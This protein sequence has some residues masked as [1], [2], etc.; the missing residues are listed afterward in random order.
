MKKEVKII[1]EPD[2]HKS[3]NG[4]VFE[5]LIRLILE[6]Q[7]YQVTK[8]VLITGLEIDLLAK[9]RLKNEVLY[10]ECKAKEKPKS[11]EIKKFIFAV[12]YGIDG[13]KADYGYFIHTEELDSH[14][15]GLQEQLER[16]KP[17]VSFIGPNKIFE[18]LERSNIVETFSKTEIEG[19]LITKLTLAYSY[20]GIFYVAIINVGSIP[21]FFS[22]FDKSLKPIDDESTI[23]L[24]KDSLKDIQELEYL[25]VSPKKESK[26]KTSRTK[27]RETNEKDTITDIK[28][29]ENWYDYTPASI[30]HFIGRTNLKREIRVFIDNVRKAETN[31][32]VFLLDGKSGWGK[33]S[34][35]AELRGSSQ[36]LKYWKSRMHVVAVDTRSANTVNFVGLAF[37]KLVTSALE[38]GFIQKTI[39]SKDL[40]ITS[41]YNVLDDESVKELFK[42]LKKRKK[43]LVL[44]FDQFED[45]FRDEKLFDA[46][47]QFCIDV[48]DARENLVVGFSWKSEINVPFGN[49]ASN[50]FNQLRDY[51][52]CI[53]I[54]EFNQN[55]AKQVVRQLESSI[56][57]PIGNDLERRL[58]E[59]SQGY[60]WLIKKLCIHT[61]KQYEKGKSIEE[62][63]EQ[64]LNYKELF[65]NDLLEVGNEEKRL[66]DHIALRAYDGNPFDISELDNETQKLADKL[67]HM[68]LVI[69]TG[70][71]YNIYWD[72]FRDYIVTKEIPVLG[73]SYLIRQ[74]GNTCL[75]A[76]LIF[77]NDRKLPLNTLIDYYP[78]Q[79]SEKAISNI[80]LELR[81]LGLL[82]KQKGIDIFEVTDKV[83]EV[84]KE[85]FQKYITQ[86]F[87]NYTP[88]IELQKL[89]KAK[90]TTDDIKDVL[91]RIFKTEKF[92]ENTWHAYAKQL[93]IWFGLSN[94]S[95]KDRLEES[96]R[97]S[98]TYSINKVKHIPYYSPAALFDSYSNVLLGK[99]INNRKARDLNL[100]GL[101][102]ENGDLLSNIDDLQEHVYREA[103]SIDK[104]KKAYDF[105]KKKPQI[106][107]NDFISSNPK[108]LANYKTLT[109]KKQATSII[110]VWVKYCIAF[111]SGENINV[112]ARRRNNG[113]YYYAFGPNNV[114]NTIKEFAQGNL[115][116]EPNNKRKLRDIEHL[117]FLDFN[118]GE[119]KT[120]TNGKLLV[121][122]LKPNSIL[123]EFARKDKYIELFLK[124]CPDKN[125]SANIKEII[126]SENEFFSHLASYNSK[127]A[128]CSIFFAWAKFL[129]KVENGSL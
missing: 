58:V 22:I 79:I 19:N 75:D 40:R 42:E 49:K 24:L 117:G 128:K 78:K 7:E 10:A 14:A 100:I 43:T 4:T 33:S 17:N 105:I 89:S 91:K 25:T 15:S 41:P 32:R 5:E 129:R 27:E 23:Q 77:K 80:L 102:D 64:E 127:R 39:F 122:S 72:I 35:L 110:F 56:G 13:E 121:E 9:H 65:D 92:E 69:R 81:S 46:F 106:S 82:K 36:T 90:I 112:R 11:D 73:E 74:S 83:T 113:I 118:E 95:I 60:P 125:T 87:E 20:I 71:T 119:Y 107:Q 51:A 45:K 59:S 18:T 68:R 28:E 37:K 84:S 85:F 99:P 98:G 108:I 31:D 52:K 63:L 97:G 26:E 48:H 12:D 94:L 115:T 6:K 50:Q 53:T 61:L 111:E 62:L 3:K 66:L 96:K 126:E 30:K 44:V 120:N 21:K 103:L 1:L 88:Y 38:S 54:P 93:S 2:V 47:Y 57:K 123:A 116:L 104:L 70:T 34:L 8:N 86:K 16:N 29:S 76:F 67:I 55:D 101:I 109:S 124:H 114:I